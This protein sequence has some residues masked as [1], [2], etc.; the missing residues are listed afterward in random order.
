M[1]RRNEFLIG[2]SLKLN[3]IQE[4]RADLTP[5]PGI[6]KNREPTMT[7][8]GSKKGNNGIP[9]LPSGGEKNKE[10]IV[11]SAQFSIKTFL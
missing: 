2:T 7:H 1:E 4:S 5:S 6:S 10:A 8:R 3:V 11:F 9:P